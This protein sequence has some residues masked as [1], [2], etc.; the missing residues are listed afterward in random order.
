MIPLNAKLITAEALFAPMRDKGSAYL[1]PCLHNDC[2]LSMSWRERCM[3]AKDAAQ[4]ILGS[5]R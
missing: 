1:D 2:A 3:V 4:L 5:L